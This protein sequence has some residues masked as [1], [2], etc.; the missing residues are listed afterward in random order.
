M[1]VVYWRVL[2]EYYEAAQSGSVPSQKASRGYHRGCNTQRNAGEWDLGWS[3]GYSLQPERKRTFIWQ[4][5][6]TLPVSIFYLLHQDKLVH[7]SGGFSSLKRKEVTR[8]K[9]ILNILSYF[10]VPVFWPDLE[11]TFLIS[12]FGIA[13]LNVAFFFFFFTSAWAWKELN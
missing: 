8:T 7:P 6:S 9:V 1:L 3:A 2:Y 12:W 13:I 10:Y 4:G 11:Y 5:L